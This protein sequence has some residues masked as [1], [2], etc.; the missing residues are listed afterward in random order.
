MKDHT[1]IGKEI[2]EILVHESEMP[3]SLSEMEKKIKQ[4]MLFLGNIILHV[5]LAWLAVRYPPQTRSCPH[6]GKEAKYKR[7]RRSKLLTVFGGVWY[8]RAYYGCAN[9]GKG[10]CPLDKALGLRPNAMSAEVERLAGLVGVQMAFGKGSDL[11][12]ELMLLESSDQSLDKA[13]QAYGH[14][15]AKQEA[16]WVARCEDGDELLHR[17]REVRPPIRIYGTLDGG[18]VQTRA[19]KGEEQPWRELKVGAWFE[20]RGKPPT[21][22]NGLW[23]IK[24]ENITYYADIASAEDFSPLVWA[25]G[26]QR[27]AQL[28]SELIFLADGARWIWDLVDLHFPQAVQ[29]V[30]WFHACEYIAPVAK[31]AFQD[32]QQQL[33]W[34]KQVQDDLWHGKLDEVV[35]A[36][37]QYCDPQ[38]EDDP[39]QKAVTYYTNNRHRMDYPTYR[40]NGYQIGSGTIESA[41]K[42][43]AE[44]RMKVSG[45]RWNFDSARL[46]AKARA[47]FL[48]GNWNSLATR[49]E[50]LGNAA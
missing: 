11:L 41:I 8:Y 3:A 43:I 38:R 34:I 23:A 15:V 9:C 28:A 1:A 30:D 16:E 42:Q 33:L 12:Q 6:C 21:K 2:C 20:A 49:R 13:T 22:P 31:L 50:S 48:S 7:K 5:W 35:A 14:E 4:M 39:A 36:C 45:A 25:T 17:Q 19:P 26:V 47:A 44:K 29:I 40:A 46:V 37:A 32:K 18:R 10:H 27:H 24:A